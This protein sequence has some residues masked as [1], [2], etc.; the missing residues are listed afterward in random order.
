M[1]YDRLT[2]AIGSLE[3][4]TTIL[5]IRTASLRFFRSNPEKSVAKI[6]NLKSQIAYFLPPGF[7]TTKLFL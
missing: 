3:L 1:W 5:E 6:S 4:H 2:G 7:P